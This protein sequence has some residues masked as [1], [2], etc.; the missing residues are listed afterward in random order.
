MVWR[1]VNHRRRAVTSPKVEPVVLKAER[2][3][4][5][6]LSVLGCFRMFNEAEIGLM[7]RKVIQGSGKIL[8]V[9]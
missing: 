5:T 4:T 1:F 7:N 3:S 9:G 6:L 2:L 8:H